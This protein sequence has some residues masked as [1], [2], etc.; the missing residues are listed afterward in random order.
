M[1]RRCPVWLLLAVL[2]TGGAAGVSRA[3]K[4]SLTPPVPAS[5]IPPTPGPTP[6]PVEFFRK[7]LVMS[8]SERFG[9]LTNRPTAMRARLMAKVREYLAL[10]PNERE[11]RL[12]ATEL[13]WYLEPLMRLSA[14]QQAA[15]LAQIPEQWRTA[16]AARLRQWDILPPAFQQAMLTNSTA[17]HFFSQVVP[18]PPVPGAEPDSRSEQLA[19]QFD[20]YFELTPAEK[21]GALRTLAPSERDQIQKTLATFEHLPPGQR[22][23]C[24]RNYAKF[25]GMTP[26]ERAEFLHNADRWAQMTPAE[27]QNWRDLVDRVPVMPPLPG[28]AQGV[29]PELYPPGTR[30]LRASVATN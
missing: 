29:P 1:N 20:Q 4:V 5:L 2:L 17:V 26:G 7:L 3:D 23:R 6:C 28:P 10:D 13:R 21:A 22:L 30:A 16:V 19:A 9:A 12:Q 18:Q 14:E 11:L 8:P 15:R 25:A 24:L 27:R